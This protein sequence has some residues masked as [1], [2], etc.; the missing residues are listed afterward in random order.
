VGD[1]GFLE[2]Q[3]LGSGQPSG[4]FDPEAPD[5]TDGPFALTQPGT[6]ARPRED[7]PGATR[8][9]EA[10][11]GEAALYAL[12]VPLGAEFPLLLQAWLE[13]PLHDTNR[14]VLQIEA[15]EAKPS[16]NV[17][18]LSYLR[19]RYDEA[20]ALN[21][22]PLEEQAWQFVRDVLGRDVEA[23]DEKPEDEREYDFGAWLAHHMGSLLRRYYR[24]YDRVLEE[25][26]RAL[27][28][29]Q[30]IQHARDVYERLRAYMPER[31]DADLKALAGLLDGGAAD[32]GA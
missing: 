20:S 17:E 5:G 18:R 10:A 15:E 9:R 2:E 26:H 4:P 29:A 23:D 32:N 19:A 21:Q 12:R 30:Q 3:V 22:M 16:P 24:G 7:Q 31:P 27:G 11:V 8:R 1:D 28:R 14:L 13:S 6:V 25:R